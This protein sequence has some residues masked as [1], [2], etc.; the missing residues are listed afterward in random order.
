MSDN[1]KPPLPEMHFGKAD[2]KP[3]DWRKFKDDSPDDDEEL[4][5]TPPSMVA[6]LGF[7]PLELD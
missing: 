1:P 6:I 7:D 3:L 2:A 4:A 5:E